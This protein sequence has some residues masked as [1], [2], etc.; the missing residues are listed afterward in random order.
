MTDPIRILIVDDTPDIRML[1]TV[2]LGA[3][4]GFEP[5]GEAADG[6]EAVRMAGELKPDAILLDLAM[7]VMDG[8]QAT[9]EIRKVSPDSRIV[10]LSGFSKDRLSDEAI[11]AGA[12]A[13]IEKGTSPKQIA[14]IV[15]TVCG[16]PRPP[17][18]QQAIAEPDAPPPAPG[19]LEAWRRRIALAVEHVG[20]LTGAFSS[21][22]QTVRSRVAFDRA[23]FSLSERRCSRSDRNCP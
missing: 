12:D 16:S 1:L 11:A 6:A 17:R 23:E 7:P 21:F 8:L 22:G 15:R 14:D 18:V 5:V 20:E 19:G 3:L 9:P 4:G 10:I 2:A 13:Y